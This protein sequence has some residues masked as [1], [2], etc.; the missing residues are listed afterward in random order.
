MQSDL[1]TGDVNF[2]LISDFEEV[3]P[4]AVFDGLVAVEN[5]YK[6]AIYFSN[7]VTGVSVS[8]SAN[9]SNVTLSNAKFTSEGFL[10]ITVPPN[11]ARII[12]L[13]LS[14]DYAD[15]NTDTTYIIIQQQ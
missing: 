7:G 12:T 15:G 8:K 14:S 6:T 10:T 1:T 11:A 13:T 2:T 3:K 9:A 4:I 5:K